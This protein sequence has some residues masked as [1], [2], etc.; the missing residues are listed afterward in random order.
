MKKVGVLGGGQLGRMLIQAAIDWNLE[1]HILEANPNAPCRY[2]ASEFVV[3]DITDY[4]TV[5]DFGKH[6]DIVTIEIENVNVEAL[7]QLEKQGVSVFPQPHIIKIIQ[8]KRLQKQFYKANHIPTADFVLV[9]NRA[10]IH[11]HID[12]LPA[13][14]KL[15]R[16]GYDGRGVM[17]LNDEN[18]M[19]QAFDA[20][21]LL[22]KAVDIEKEIAVI[23]AR[24]QNGAVTAFPPV[25]LVFDPKYNLVDYLLSPAQIPATLAEKAT[26][27]AKEV[28]TA[29][30]MI[31]LLAVEL[32]YSK[33][34][35]LLV[36]EVAPRPHNSGHHTIEANV[37]SQFQQHLR[38]ILNLPLGDTG[39]ITPAAMINILGA[40]GH[41][42]VAR[43]DGLETLLAQS[44]V[45]VHL[46]GK[47][48]TKPSRKMGHFTIIDTDNNINHLQKKVQQLKG[49][50][51]VVSSEG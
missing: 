11:E 10:E 28:I 15:G 50:M 5:L 9:E 41:Q 51:Q 7:E 23:V 30:D 3:G 44:G 42:G 1:I 20:P 37:T 18:D 4:Q 48:I 46:Y 21:S 45:Y 14:N 12:F 29:F 26:K 8:N 6:M 31:G 24:N 19:D 40:E 43:Y 16:G 32:F 39:I 49:I 34:G 13:F 25:E 35:E 47:A 38:A 27:I 17:R 2:V 22:E 33:S 36:N